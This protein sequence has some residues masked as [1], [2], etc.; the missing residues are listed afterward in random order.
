MTSRAKIAATLHKH[1]C[2]HDWHGYT[3]G[4]GRW[5][6]GE[7]VCIVEVDGRTYEVQQGDRDCSSSI[8]ECWRVALQGTEYA[9]VLDGATYTGNMRCVF[10]KSGLF[11]WHPMSDGYI[12]QQGD[13]YLNERDH[14]AMCQSAIPDVLSEFL[15]NENGDIIGGMVGDQTGRESVVRAYYNYPWDG[16]LAYTGR[17]DSDRVGWYH[18]GQGWRYV[19]SDGRS[20]I[21]EWV[22]LDAWYWFDTRGYAVVGWQRIGGAWYYFDSNCRMMTGW[23]RDLGKWYYLMKT[24]EM[25]EMCTLEINGK[26]Y[27]FGSTG[28]MIEG[29]VPVDK[30]GALILS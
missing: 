20:C 16:I 21:N 17:A 11:E 5:G 10:V 19:R 4:S 22:M 26:T 27:A 15:I 3:Q 7:G 1:L 8:I 28:A 24:G 2:Q 14:T 18:D 30:N 29:S 12:A 6:D 13:I 23:I 25:A 9:G